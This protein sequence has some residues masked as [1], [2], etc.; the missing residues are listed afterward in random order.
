M[1]QSR[2]HLAPQPFVVDANRKL[3]PGQIPLTSIKPN[4]KPEA[5]STEPNSHRDLHR[6]ANL[7]LEKKIL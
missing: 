4:E 6:D 3:T 5:V 7:L 2:Q 1:T